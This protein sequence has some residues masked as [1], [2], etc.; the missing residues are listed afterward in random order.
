MDCLSFRAL[1]SIGCGS[2]SSN[3]NQSGFW[4]G[5]NVI[6]VIN[7]D[8]QNDAEQ[9]LEATRGL[10]SS[11]CV[12]TRGFLPSF[13]ATAIITYAVGAPKK[14]VVLRLHRVSTSTGTQY[15]GL[16]EKIT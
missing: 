6:R 7:T 15:V 8:G 3:S 2:W 10:S 9:P 4:S 5:N 14:V 1:A 13:T 16:M 12:D 11:S